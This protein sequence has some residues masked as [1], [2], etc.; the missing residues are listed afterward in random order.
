MGEDLS[1]LSEAVRFRI[2]R[3]DAKGRSFGTPRNPH[4]PTFEEFNPRIEELPAGDLAGSIVGRRHGIFPEQ[5]A[6]IGLMS[7]DDLLRFR[8]DDPMSATR[9]SGGLSITGGHHRIDEIA[10]RVRAGRIAPE[11]PIRILVHD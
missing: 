6:R 2:A 11:T 4:T 7:N 9:G 5:A 3:G 1:Q 8:P 10:A